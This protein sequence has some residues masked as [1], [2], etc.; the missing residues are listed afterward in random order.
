M[1][2]ASTSQRLFRPDERLLLNTDSP[3][4]LYHQMEQ[5]LIDRIRHRGTVGETIPREMDLMKIFGVSR[6]TVKKT[7]EQLS[8]KGLIEKKRAV[9]TKIVRLTITE[10]LGRLRS[11][12]EQMASDN[13]V[14]RT[15][16][17]S[18]GH[19]R[20]TAS[21]AEQLGL[22]PGKR[23]L[24]IRRLRGTEEAFPIVY[25]HSE[26]P[27]H[28]GIDPE[29]DFQASLYQIIEQQYRIPID[30]AEEKIL[31][32]NAT[33]TEAQHLG[34]TPGQAVLVMERTAY[35]TGDRPIEFVRAVYLPE[36]YSFSIK[37][38]R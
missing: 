29:Q 9:G 37:L 31:A 8:D 15:R 5:V 26:L 12:S 14:V 32:R 21:A 6:A 22:G 19:R 10:D 36:H 34:I 13:K 16:V 20:P 24:S 25:L 17:L 33:K 28:L 4:P 30:W 3:V 11:Y 27:E 7:T 2:K 35:S 38:K 23:V 1:A 18:V